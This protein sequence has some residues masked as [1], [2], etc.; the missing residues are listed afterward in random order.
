MIPGTMGAAIPIASQSSTKRK[1]ES[2][3]KKYWVIAESAPASSLRLKWARS[4]RGLRACGWNS[5]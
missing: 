3:L 5:G 4:S 1:Y 2:A